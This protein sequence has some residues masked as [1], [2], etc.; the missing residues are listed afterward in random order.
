QTTK[1]MGQKRFLLMSILFFSI[2]PTVT[3]FAETAKEPVTLETVVVTA[4]KPEDSFQT[5]DVDKE[6][7]PVFFR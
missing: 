7:T 4:K 2:F 5:G 3:V 6:Q 1:K